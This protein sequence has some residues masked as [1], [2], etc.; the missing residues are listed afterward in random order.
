MTSLNANAHDADLNS[1]ENEHR[2][3]WKWSVTDYPEKTGHKVFSCFSCGGGSTMG[4]K[5]AG[6]DVIGNCEIDPRMASIY[7]KNHHPK[8]SF[9]M[10]IRE[11]TKL[12]DEK[13]PEELYQLDIL[14]GSPPCSVFSTIGSREKGWGKEKVFRE[15]QAAQRLDDLFDYF[16][17]VGKRLQPK[18]IIAEN[19]KGLI[20]GNAKGY[21]NHIFKLLDQAGY[22][23]QL[24]LLDA[25]RMGVPQSRERTFFICRR[26][27]LHLDKIKLAFS[28]PII[29]FGEIRQPKGIPA[30]GKDA[31]LIKKLKKEKYLTEV[32]GKKIYYRAVIRD[33]ELLHTVTATS[34]IYRFATRDA[35]CEK[36]YANACTFPQDYDFGKEDA[37]YI[38]GMSVPQ[39]MM[40][41]IAT[42][43]KEQ[44]FDKK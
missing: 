24:F 26:K 30:T 14:D 3:P 34:N 36:D 9:V 8:Y 44:W 31:E 41:Q 4:Y 28:E 7:Q 27:D 29:R 12:P 39:V 22:E 19:V 32:E 13:I 6:F 43:V 17:E 11:F 18:V 42:K 37:K 38:C 25:S 2:F 23:S 20:M 40:A 33:N 10:D 5:L 16:I 21:V 35:L 15:G 1:I